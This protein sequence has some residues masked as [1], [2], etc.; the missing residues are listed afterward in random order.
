MRRR[1]LLRTAAL[2]GAAGIA[3]CTTDG[4]T[5]DANGDGGGGGGGSSPTDSPTGSPTDPSTE[6]AADTSS[7]TP[8]GSPGESPSNTESPEDGT[9][10][11]TPAA[12]GLASQSFEVTA[13][14]CG[15]GRNTVDI[16]FDGDEV[17]LDGVI[18]G[19]NGCYTAEQG[20]IEY[21][22]ANDRLHVNVRAYEPDDAEMCTQCIVDI[23]YRA[24]YVFEN[25]APS[26]VTVAH[27][28]RDIAG[29]A[30]GSASAGAP[31]SN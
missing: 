31:T 17:T 30:H 20:S 5:N 8:A 2:A 14:G 13:Q 22:S 19:S 15:E 21:D 23:E 27:D 16:D 9:T 24:R 25:E 28:G 12:N 6:P 29:A 7:E 10:T 18:D 4:P 11:G 26:E 1:A 3:G